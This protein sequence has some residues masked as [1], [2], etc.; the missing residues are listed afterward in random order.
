M[1]DALRSVLESDARVAYALV[2]GS[3]ARG[4]AHA[5]SDVDVAVGLTPG[6]P[7]GAIAIG[8]LV[9]RLEAAVRR[10]VDV[11]L[12]DAAPPALAYRIFRD[13]I[14]VK[15]RDHAALAARKARAILEYLDF[16]P[17][18]EQLTRGVLAVAAR[19]R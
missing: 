11:V 19:G 2:F 1:L 10:P 5:E 6:D 15:E 12:L 4:T 16:R 17:F 18:E 8:D 9:S 7:L 3:S 13:G 14:V